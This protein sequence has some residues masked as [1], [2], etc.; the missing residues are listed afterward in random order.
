MQ[1]MHVCSCIHACNYMHACIHIYIYTVHTSTHT[2]TC[3]PY[4]HIHASMHAY[5]RTYE[6]EQTNK[7]RQRSIQISYARVYAQNL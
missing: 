2:R 1:R 6:Y 3:I 4:T 7:H 5:I